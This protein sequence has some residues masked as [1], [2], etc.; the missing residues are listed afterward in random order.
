VSSPSSSSQ[1]K[2]CFTFVEFAVLLAITWMPDALL[3]VAG[4]PCGN[5][6]GAAK[7]HLP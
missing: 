1:V 4:L 2:V 5:G 6:V 3:H 7:E